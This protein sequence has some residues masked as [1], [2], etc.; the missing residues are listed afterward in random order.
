MRTVITS[1]NIDLVKASLPEEERE[2]VTL[3]DY[4]EKLLKYIPAEI[5]ALYV[6]VYGI[7]KAAQENI[8][9]ELIAW[10]IFGICFLGTILYLWRIEKD[11][12]WSQVIISAIAFAVWVFAL[13][14]PFESLSW[15]NSV[16]GAILLPVYTFFIPIIVG[17]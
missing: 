13:G 16:Y 9:F 6:T 17:K 10:I 2:K 3:D 15:Y 5:I 4:K 7:A 1:K 14:G 8:P 11:V 12:T